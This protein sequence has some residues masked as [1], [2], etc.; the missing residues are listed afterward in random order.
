MTKVLA[1]NNKGQMTY[2][3]AS[4]ENRGKGRCNHIAHQKP[5]ESKEEFLERAEKEMEKLNNEKDLDKE[6]ELNVEHISYNDF[7]EEIIVHKKV[8]GK[9]SDL[10]NSKN[11]KIRMAVAQKGYAFEQLS[12]DE[13]FNIRRYIADQGYKLDRFVN[14]PDWLV[15]Y[16]VAERGY[17]L[18]QLVNDKNSSVRTAVARQ[19]YGLDK[20]VNDK[21]WGVRVEVAKCGYGLDQLVNDDSWLVRREVARQGYNLDKLINDE[22]EHVINAALKY[23]GCVK[24]SE[25]KY[26]YNKEK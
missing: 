24:L 10:I 22:N 1:L 4:E 15:R 26:C 16:T 7:N 17:G 12:N 5:N 14:N 2:C 23:S 13:D 9:I 18:D 11:W 6:I 3:S 19:S 21:D 25:N 20:L 8:K